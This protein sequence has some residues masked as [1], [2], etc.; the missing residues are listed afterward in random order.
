MSPWRKDYCTVPRGDHGTSSTGLPQVLPG[1][2][3]C[4]LSGPFLDG[5][6]WTCLD[7]VLMSGM[8]VSDPDHNEHVSN[9]IDGPC[10]DS[11]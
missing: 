9:R 3:F 4:L 11:G 8:E 5:P 1:S 6:P 7:V 2:L 10:I